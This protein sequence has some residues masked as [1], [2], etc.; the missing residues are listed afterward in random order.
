MKEVAFMTDQDANGNARKTDEIEVL[1]QRLA[2]E[3][4]IEEH[5]ARE[6][7]ELIGTDWPSLVREARFLKGRH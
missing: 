5:K 4:S 3:M 7:I 1:A 6:L 2:R